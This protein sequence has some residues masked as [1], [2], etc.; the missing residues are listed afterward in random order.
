MLKMLALPDYYTGKI[1]FIR[2]KHVKQVMHLAS[3][4]KVWSKRITKSS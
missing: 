3:A 1:K 2:M 4:T